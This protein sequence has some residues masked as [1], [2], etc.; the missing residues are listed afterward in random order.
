MPYAKNNQDL[1]PGSPMFGLSVV[2]TLL[3]FSYVQPFCIGSDKDGFNDDDDNSGAVDDDD[4]DNCDED[5]ENDIEN[6][7]DKAELPQV[8]LLKVDFLFKADVIILE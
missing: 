7:T 4:H 3:Y 6:I 2:P 8:E 5:G 1:T